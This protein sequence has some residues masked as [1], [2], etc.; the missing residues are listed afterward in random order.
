MYSVRKVTVHLGYST[1]I[2]SS[3]SRLP[4]SVLLLCDIALYSVV[5]QQL[6]CNTGKVFV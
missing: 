1:E 4:L 5:K 6:K 3:V 2:W